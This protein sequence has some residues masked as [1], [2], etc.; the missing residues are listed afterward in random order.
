VRVPA[1]AGA[2][3]RLW[4]WP[5]A[6]SAQCWCA[7]TSVC[8][9][10]RGRTCECVHAY[11]SVRVCVCAVRLRMAVW[12]TPADRELSA[13]RRGRRRR[14]AAQHRP[15]VHLIVAAA[16]AAHS[17]QARP[18][19]HRHPDWARPLQYLRPATS[20]SGL[21]SPCHICAGTRLGAATSA[22]GLGSPRHICAGTRAAEACRNARPVRAAPPG[23]PGVR[24]SALPL[25]SRSCTSCR[26]SRPSSGSAPA[27]T[28]HAHVS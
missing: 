16:P 18:L 25:H 12:A 22:P 27:G 20:A 8:V 2:L 14:R 1:Y 15:N 9:H 21:G 19:P 28:F 10:A 11:V 3:V 17:I 26:S 6:V 24:C 4:D 13:A 5:G 23:L 7:R